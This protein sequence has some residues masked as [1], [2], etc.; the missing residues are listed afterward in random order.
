VICFFARG[1]YTPEIVTQALATLGLE[2]SPRD[3]EDL[4][5]KILRL[6][7]AF[8]E[9]EGFSLGKIRIPNRILETPSSFGKIEEDFLRRAL[10][11]TV[12]VLDNK[13]EM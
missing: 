6:K 3:L 11:W 12:N 7:H 8:K 2:I 4:G 5:T 1:V 13:I 9:R 10:A